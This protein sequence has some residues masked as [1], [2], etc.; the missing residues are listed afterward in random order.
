MN[1]ERMKILTMLSEGKISAQEADKLIAA[2][3]TPKPVMKK[4]TT[5]TTTTRT[6]STIPSFL[7]VHV[8]PKSEGG[9]KVKIKVPF[10][11][12]RAGMK[13]ASLL[14]N[15]VQDKVTVALDEKGVDIDL[16]NLTKENLDEF[17]STF[18]EMELDVDSANE[19]VRI[20]CE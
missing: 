12:L 9:D 13:L 14:P 8:E 15:D 18:S 6:S 20:F 16:K 2:L 19:R 17:I 3:D 11:L 10:K 5:K 7:Y 1:D 4:T